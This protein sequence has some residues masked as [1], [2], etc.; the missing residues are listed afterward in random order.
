M[1]GFELAPEIPALAGAEKPA[2]IEFVTRLHGA[3]V[4]SI[5]AGARVVRLLPPLNLTSAEAD[6]GLKLIEETVRRLAS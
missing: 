2:S 4:L 1:I 5:P 3:G 6:D